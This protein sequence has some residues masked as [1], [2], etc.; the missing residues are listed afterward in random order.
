M[1]IL[2]LFVC[3][4]IGFAFGQSNSPLWTNKP[5]TNLGFAENNNRFEPLFESEIRYYG[6]YGPY[7]FY[8]ADNK[9]IIGQEKE[10]TP[11]ERW[12]RHE[13]R[14]RGGMVEPIGKNYIQIEWINANSEALIQ[15]ESKNHHTI[16]FQS[17]D[18]SEQTIKSNTYQELHYKNLYP[19][20]NLVLTLPEEGGLKYAFEI[21]PEGDYRDIGMRY[22]NADL[23]V[24][25][26]GELEISSSLLKLKDKQ[27]VS[28]LKNSGDKISTSFY[29]SPDGIVR[30]S[31][32]DYNED[33]SLILDP[34]L[35]T[36]LPFTDVQ[37]AYDIA[38][39]FNGYSSILGEHGNQVAHYDPDGALEWV[40]VSPGELNDFYG[41]LDMNPHTGDTYYMFMALF[42]GIQDIWRLDET[43][44][45][46]ASIYY[47]GFDGDPGELWRLNYNSVADEVVVG[48]GGLPRESHLC[49]VD[50][51]LTANNQYAPLTPVPPNLTDATFL[52]VD[53]LGEYIYL[54]CSGDGPDN[55][56]YNNVLYKLEQDNP[57]VIVWEMPTNYEFEEISCIGY[58]GYEV[59]T[60]EGPD[61]YS[62][63]G[64][65]GI[66]CSYDL[67]TYD[68]DSLH[69]WNKETGEQLGGLYVTEATPSVY[70]YLAYCGGIDTDPCGNV[71]VGTE[72]SIIK[73]SRELEYIE[74]Y[75]VPDTCYD[76]R[77]TREDLFASGK[78]FIQMFDGPEYVTWE[79][80][81]EETT[82]GICD[83]TAS[84]ENTT[85]CPELVLESV[86]WSPS[87]A[88]GETATDLCAGWHT[89][90]I[91]WANEIGDTITRVDSIEVMIG[92][93]GDLEIN[94]AG[95][96]CNGDCDG[97]LEI[98]VTDGLP[99]F[100]YDLDGDINTTGI[101]TDLC[102]GIYPLVVTDDEGCTFIREVEVE[103]LDALE[104]LEEFTD[105]GCP[106]ACNG[107]ITLTPETGIEP[108][109]FTVAGETN[110]T[111]IFTELCVG[112]YDI[113]VVDGEGCEYESSITIATGESIGLEIV[114][115]NNPSCYGFTDGSVTVTTLLG[116][117]P[118]IY[119]WLPT[120]PI[121]GA[122]F[123]NL[124]AGTYTAFAQDANGCTDTLDIIIT[125]PDSLWAEMSLTHLLCYGDST[126]V[127]VVDSV[128]NPQGDTDNITFV[129]TPN[130]FGAD[131]V[132]VDSAYHLY[133]GE[134]ILTVT[135]DNGCSTTKDFTITSPDE[136]V[137]AELGIESALCRVFHYQ[138]GNGVVFAAANGG[139][140][141][142][143]YSWIN[144]ET[145]ETS[146]NS[147]WGGLNPGYYRIRVTDDN[148]C[149][150][151]ETLQ[152]DSINP[153][154]SFDVISDQLD[155][156][157]E[158]TELVEAEFINTSQGFSNTES[159]TT[160]H[161][162]LNHPNSEWIITHDYFFAPDTSYV[163]EAVY[164][165]C[166]VAI[167]K[168]GC[169]DTTCKDL[170]VH[171]QPEF[172][173]PNI[174]TPGNG[175]GNDLFTFEFRTVGMETFHCII[176]NRWGKKVAELNH[177]TDGWDGTDLA[178]NE[179][180]AGTYFFTYDAVS[181]N[182][183]A[184]TGQGTVQLVRQ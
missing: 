102:P 74:S 177:V 148:G 165:V 117:E 96:S 6:D 163:G 60:G 25:Q 135:D 86:T 94:A 45:V 128:Y 100:T 89:A 63:N 161:W 160:F 5:F 71:Y 34:W 99:P 120:N 121:P 113:L 101:F 64:H 184:F 77:Y 143:D 110:T 157:C 79:L 151:T 54:L 88:V 2:L 127:A 87:G 180:T 26:N 125:E 42:G 47:V 12:E 111:G 178:G 4:S 116:E 80:S 37:Q 114:T 20:I 90:T 62:P 83:G 162:N 1:R 112:T 119:D 23:K 118:V 149:M 18:N 156:N 154:A 109:E 73:F 51:P 69:R 68:G 33:E 171:V 49:V 122:T 138:N 32:D 155:E 55:P 144:L 38:A 59:L 70:G 106:G 53:P 103:E 24:N 164:E 16:N 85:I 123:N 58:L 48:A 67:Y 15:P 13:E 126:G 72:D 14:E 153:Q 46:N 134:Y 43:G 40:W 27:P 76:L 52:E 152:L 93:S 168:N 3:L 172:I 31:L 28:W 174:F 137:F 95:Q 133:A 39:D 130:P 150:L 173:T 115:I 166:L 21:S 140:G 17:P 170:I 146:S 57:D 129:W 10:I 97:S 158:G 81:Q 108:Y 75:A 124:G 132:G 147:T 29:M 182:G 65:N 98:T 9:I 41:D 11:K 136:L 142:Y 176:V 8:F 19:G 91:K 82:C 175:G 131:G 35:V 107:T 61:W 78:N 36:A 66:A 181:T 104:I 44:T 179:C 50:G 105:E 56:L 141:D 22:S 92:A 183:T 145:L 7:T 167:N 30:F 159:D 169:V 139:V 84:V